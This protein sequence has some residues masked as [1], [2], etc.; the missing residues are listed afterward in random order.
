QPITNNKM[1]FQVE[2]TGIGMAAD[3]LADIFLPFNQIGDS[4][5]RVEGTGLGLA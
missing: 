5:H 3:Q 4:S 2:D 1:R